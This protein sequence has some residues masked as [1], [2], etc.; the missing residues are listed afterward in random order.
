MSSYAIGV[1]LGGTNLRIAAVNESG[2]L[3]AKIELA[4]KVK[5]G[6]EHV[7]DELCCATKAL[8][9]EMKGKA[10]VLCGI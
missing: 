3:L 6:R 2:K 4:T 9:Q 1:D 7:V 5:Q 8:I 10:S